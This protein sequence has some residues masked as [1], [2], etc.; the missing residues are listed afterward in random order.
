[1]RAVFDSIA[2]IRICESAENSLKLHLLSQRERPAVGAGSQ[3]H[4]RICQPFGGASRCTARLVE[5]RACSVVD[6]LQV[7][8]FS[9][10]QDQ[11]SSEELRT[12]PR[13]QES[14]AEK[15]SRSEQR[16][17]RRHKHVFSL[18]SATACDA[19]SG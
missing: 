17:S 19:R 2:V 6:L 11:A 9:A 1:M 15:Q 3:S 12:R 5:T 13:Q 14:Q 16:R 7:V 8:S 4:K 10:A 18:I